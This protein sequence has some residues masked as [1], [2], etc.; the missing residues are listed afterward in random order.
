LRQAGSARED[1]RARDAAGLHA[2]A[3]DVFRGE[4]NRRG[5]GG[6]AGRG[7]GGS[8]GGVERRR[9]RA[10]WRD[11]FAAGRRRPG[12]DATA[13]SDRRCARGRGG[14]DGEVEG[15]Q[16]TCRP[17]ARANRRSFGASSASPI[18]R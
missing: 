16:I 17:S 12:N 13:E 4:N 8:G 14:R 18:S 3:R 10:A 2:L 1:T 7:Q 9:Q 11:E 5:G 6:G 15:R